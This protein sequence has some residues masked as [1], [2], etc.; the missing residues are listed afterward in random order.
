MSWPRFRREPLSNAG[1]QSSTGGTA[2]GKFRAAFEVAREHVEERTVSIPANGQE[3]LRFQ[4][5][6]NDAGEY[7]VGLNGGHYGTITVEEADA[8]SSDT[9]VRGS[10]PSENGVDDD[11][12]GFGVL[13]TLLGLST[14][15]GYAIRSRGLWTPR[16]TRCSDTN[17]QNLANPPTARML[18]ST[19][20]AGWIADSS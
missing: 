16:R 8:D 2:D 7:E 19:T 11:I 4:R 10:T 9:L 18:R 5:R 1:S 17:P 13:T 6:F 14:A 20:T 3:E 12:P 15:A